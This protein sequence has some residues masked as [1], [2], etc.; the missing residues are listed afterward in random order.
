MN[1]LSKLSEE[2]LRRNLITLDFKGKE[3]KEVALKELLAR[4]FIRGY[5]RCEKEINRLNSLS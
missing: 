1:D 5:E 4:E 2:E 3:F